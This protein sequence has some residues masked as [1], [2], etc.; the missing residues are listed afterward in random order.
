VIVHPQ[1]ARVFSLG[2]EPILRQDGSERNDCER[3]AAKRL[4]EHFRQH[5]AAENLLFVEDALYANAPHIR[6]IQESSPHWQYLLA[7]KPLNHKR[8]FE[9]F[10]A[11]KKNRP[12]RTQA[13]QHTDSD[14]TRYQFEY[15]NN[16]A[17]SES[18]SDIRINVLHGTT[19]TK[20]SKTMTF[21]WTTNITLTRKN[22]YALMQTGRA[23]WKIENETFYTLKNQE[24]HFEPNYG[25]GNNHLSSLLATLML[26]SFLVD[27]MQAAADKLFKKVTAGLASKMK[28]W[29]ALRAVFKLE[30]IQSKHDAFCIIADSY[31]VQRE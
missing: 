29:E 27:Q 5:Y 13:H 7:I 4:L 26:F 24:Y 17:L 16:L 8:L 23:R 14:G 12:N 3:N 30:K 18:A 9:R 20:N 15:A 1:E 6:Q 2:I 10:A 28:F 21:T 31:E 22:V 19:T 25:H 11:L